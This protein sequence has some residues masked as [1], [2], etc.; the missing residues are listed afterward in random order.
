MFGLPGNCATVNKGDIT[1]SAE[2]SGLVSRVGKARG[3]GG[4][5]R[6]IQTASNGFE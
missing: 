2:R 6:L 3:Y 4:G 1:G 5:F